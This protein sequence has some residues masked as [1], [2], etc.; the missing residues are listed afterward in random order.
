[1]NF[2]NNRRRRKRFTDGVTVSNQQSPKQ[3]EHEQQQQQQQPVTPNDYYDHSYEDSKGH[4]HDERDIFESSCNFGQFVLNP[5]RCI[6]NSGMSCFQ[7]WRFRRKG[8]IFAVLGTLVIIIL[9]AVIIFCLRLLF[10]LIQKTSSSGRPLNDEVAD[11]IPVLI[12]IFDYRGE[13]T[14]G[15]AYLRRFF[16]PSVKLDPASIREPDFGGLEI[17]SRK[18]PELLLPRQELDEDDPVLHSYDDYAE[19]VEA[20]RYRSCRQPIWASRYYPSCNSFHEIDLRQDYDP[21]RATISGDDQVLDSFYISHGYFRDVWVIHQPA[22]NNTKSVLK[23]TRWKHKYGHKTYWNTLAD[24]MVMERLTASPRIVDIYGHCGSAVWVEAIPHEVEEVIIHGDGMANPE[25]LHYE[26]E[27][28]SLNNYTVEEK[29]DMALTMAESLADLHGFHGGVIVHDDVQ[30]CQWLRTEDG[31]LKLGDFNRAEVMAYNAE[32]KKYCRYRNGG[33]Y[34]NYRAPEE[35]A[36][37]DLDEGIDVYTFGNN[38]YALL[39]GLWVFYDIDDDSVVQKKVINGTRAYVDSRWKKRSYIESEL[40]DVMEKCWVHD[41]KER[42]DI[43]QVVH[44]LRKIVKENEARKSRE[45]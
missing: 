29:L 27:L 33:C 34:G 10:T 23:M 42:I 7:R 4:N 39:T 44:L 11:K 36:V 20:D 26:S 16:L 40:V 22:Q 15:W 5:C 8:F 41:P 38:I 31:R 14:G 37:M 12:P 18:Q 24:A 25:D 2:Q 45:K 9:L 21:K 35:F 1:M 3:K 17:P 13:D 32:K 30:L 6:C 19:A 43:F 28:N